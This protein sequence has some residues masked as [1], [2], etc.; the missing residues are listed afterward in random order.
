HRGPDDHGYHFEG[1]V[2]LGFRRLSIIDLDNGNQPMTNENRDIW[3]CFNGE[4]YNYQDLGKKLRSLGHNFRTRCDTEVI[5]HAY[6]EWGVH[7]VDHLV[8]MFAFSIWDRNQK[9]L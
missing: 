8:G 1:G 6:E 9:K 3:L 5:L 4:I 2:G 7:A